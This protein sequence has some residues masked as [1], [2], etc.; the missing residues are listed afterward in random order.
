MGEPQSWHQR[1]EIYFIRLES[2][3]SFTAAAAS[4]T[5]HVLDDEVALI[6]G[7]SGQCAIVAAFQHPFWR[8]LLFALH[9]HVCVGF[10]GALSFSSWSPSQRRLILWAW[11]Q[12]LRLSRTAR[13]PQLDSA[14]TPT[15][16]CVVTHI[17]SFLSKTC[18]RGSCSGL[19]SSTSPAILVLV[20]VSRHV[21][22]AFCLQPLRTDMA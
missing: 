6:D 13:H 20:L 9:L 21:A 5:G 1:V 2:G 12:W 17:L 8:W 15:R 19:R 3:R 22:T 18:P 10:F 14:E 11:R 16:K 7:M 4:H